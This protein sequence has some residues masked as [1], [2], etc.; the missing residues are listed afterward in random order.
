MKR[1]SDLLLIPTALLA[2][3]AAGAALTPSVLAE[4]G[5][6]SVQG[7]VELA[8]RT[9]SVDGSERKY[10]EDFDGLGSSLYLGRLELN[11]NDLG[12]DALDYARVS[13]RGLG[14]EPY[15]SASI[16]V[17]RKDVYDVRFSTRKQSYLYN[18]FELTD[19]EDGHSWNTDSRLTDLDLTLYPTDRLQVRIGY[20]ENRRSGSSIFMKDLQ[21]DVFL[22]ESPVDT[23]RETFSVGAT[24]QA[25]PVDL[26]FRQ[27]F[28]T[29]DRDFENVTEGN[30]GLN[31]G[32][33]AL[34]NFYDWRQRESG[35]QDLTQ[36]QLRA[37]I[38]SRVDVSVGI[39][40]T[41]LG[42]DE[43]DSRVAVDADGV[44]FAGAPFTWTNGFS[45][46]TLDNDL[47]AI[48]ADVAIL[49]ARPVTLH[50]KYDS[51]DR[52]VEGA[53]SRDLEG[54]G[55]VTT[56]DTRFDWSTE[57]VTGLFEI[58]PARRLVL[59][60]G[61]RTTDRML[62]REGFDVLRDEDFESDGDETLVGGVTW[63]ATD[64]FR[65]SADYEDGDVDA[66]FATTSPFETERSRV[67]A[68]FLPQEAMRIDVSWLD[69][70]NTNA[71]AAFPY[72]TEGTTASLSFFHKA[73]DRVSYRLGYAE[74]D[75]E[76]VTAVLFDGPGFGG[77]TG[78]DAGISFFT[79]D[80]T[81]WNA[82]IDWRWP[83]ERV[84]T[85]L[86]WWQAEAD[87]NNSLTGENLGLVNDTLVDQEFHDAELGFSYSFPSGLYVGAGLRDFDYDDGNDRLDYDGSMWTMRA[88]F[89]F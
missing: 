72:M 33:T 65:F 82:Q 60:A 79:T 6:S 20:Q 84:S 77:P 88:G 25:G 80:N 43:L 29:Y 87:G 49:I 76:S 61:Y 13:A 81:Q 35:S 86:R 7:D 85:Y 44:D 54:S 37:P 3:C 26:M 56:V 9:V 51:L 67:R 50:L 36:V 32:N 64:W 38:G 68:S 73:N 11:W 17:G 16:R 14:G 46:V 21:R 41:F 78:T 22:L 57:S 8:Y 23:V 28:S 19:D 55:T 24:L 45:D 42:D 48:E 70:E 66:A 31:T 18:L 63:N 47:Q 59:R 2:A 62:V 83:G 5:D 34:L 71:G 75:V 89:R 69:F 4:D 39:A 12:A 30:L 52:E 74:Q 40:G 58:R 53:G 15:E 1:A 10:N 27:S